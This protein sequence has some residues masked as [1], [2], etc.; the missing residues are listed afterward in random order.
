MRITAVFTTAGSDPLEDGANAKL[1][2]K[3]WN[4]SA[5]AVC[6]QSSWAVYTNTFSL[7][8]FLQTPTQRI[9]FIF[10]IVSTQYKYIHNSFYL[11]QATCHLPTR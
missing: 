11:A 8:S 1:Y 10:A 4:A 5:P 6:A 7:Q 9:A 2:E 3:G